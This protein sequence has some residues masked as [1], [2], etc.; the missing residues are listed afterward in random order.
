MLKKSLPYLF[1]L[2]I[3]LV[4]AL[5]NFTPGT[6]LTGWDTLHPEVDFGLNMGRLVSGVWRPD[7]GLGAV[8]GHSHMADLPRVALLWLMHFVLPLMTLRYAY[9]FLCLAIGPIGVYRLILRLTGGK[10]LVALSSGLFYLCNLSTV[11]QFYAPLEMFPTQWAWLPWIVFLSLKVIE[12]RGRGPI[13]WFAAATLMAAPQAYAAHLWYPFFGVY[14]L[15]LGSYF[16]VNQKKAVLKKALALI[17]VTLAVN[18]FWLLPN[19]YFIKTTSSV[20]KESKQNRLFSQEYRLRNR[21]NGYLA[22]VAFLRGFYLDWESYSIIQKKFTYLM[23]EWRRHL[24]NPWV[25]VTGA[26]LFTVSLAG[27]LYAALKRD[28]RYLPFLPFFIVPFIILANR[29]PP[30]DLFFD[31]LIRIP[32]LE[33][34]LRFVFTKF[35]ILALLGYTVFFSFAVSLFLEKISLHKQQIATVALGALLVFYAFPMF[36]GGLIGP[37]FRIKMPSYYAE[38]WN[39]MNTQEDGRVLSLPLQTFSGWQYYDWGYQGAG[40]LWFGL[41]QPLL[42]RD[43]DRW[44]VANEQAFREFQYSLYAKRQNEFEANLNKYRVSYLVWDHSNIV[45]AGK[46]LDQKL[47]AHETEELIKKL[48]ESHR[49][50]LLKR[51]GKIDVYATHIDTPREAVKDLTHVVGPPY[52]WT[53]TDQAYLDWGDYVS[54]ADPR[55]TDVYY[56]LRNLVTP[57]DRINPD[58]FTLNRQDFF[59]LPAT[60]YKL[61]K[62]VEPAA[63]EDPVQ[64]AARSRGEPLLAPLGKNATP[65]IGAARIAA[66]SSRAAPAHTISI[67]GQSYADFES[68]GAIRSGTYLPLENL[69]HTQGYILKIRSKHLAGLPLRI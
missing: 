17:A 45:P 24:D 14:V 40:F 20:P 43:S 32:L 69:P 15:F 44:S 68:Q 21:E 31:L 3:T 59:R 19:L 13:L 28:K 25:Y 2:G 27:A 52:R 22:D 1:L 37:Q 55:L 35:S 65:V 16:M 39:Y 4:I 54:S 46:N 5:L 62:T 48:S 12:E 60:P 23:P 36:Q 33:E 58:F 26:S 7:Q 41:K 47:Y 50:K 8:A 29:T 63:P 53:S 18:S 67:A 11:Q 6:F 38:F 51:I 34:A 57:A 9:I 56:P 64:Y 30:F 42:D 49:L 10:S 66:G 61:S